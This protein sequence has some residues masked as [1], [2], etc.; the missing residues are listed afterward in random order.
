MDALRNCCSDTRDYNWRYD[1]E[2]GKTCPRSCTVLRVRCA[3]THADAE[4]GYTLHCGI[5]CLRDN[6]TGVW[7]ACEDGKI[8]RLY[9]KVILCS[10]TGYMASISCLS[11][12]WRGLAFPTVFF[13]RSLRPRL[14]WIPSPVCSVSSICFRIIRGGSPLRY[15]GTTDSGFTSSALRGQLRA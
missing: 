10:G 15:G 14:P 12:M 9:Q 6:H 2:R 13:L 8:L 3:D 4:T 11:L 5:H 7:S 1:E